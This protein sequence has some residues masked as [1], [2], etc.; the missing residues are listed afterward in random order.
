MLYIVHIMVP[1]TR[2][3][4]LTIVELGGVLLVRLDEVKK[5]VK[6]DGKSYSRF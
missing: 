5:M 2:Y 1:S 4:V 6:A 3:Q